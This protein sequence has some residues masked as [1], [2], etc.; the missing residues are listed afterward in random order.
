MRSASSAPRSC[1][2]RGGSTAASSIFTRAIDFGFSKTPRG[3]GARSGTSAEML[4]R[5]GPGHPHVPAA[6]RSSRAS[7]GTAADGHGHH[8]M[9]GYLTPLAFRA[10]ADP[11]EFPDQ[12][13][14][15][16]CGRGRRGSSTRRAIARCARHAG[17]RRPACSIRCSAGPMPKSPSRA[18]ASTSRRRW[19]RSRSRRSADLDV[20]EPIDQRGDGPGTPERSMFDGLDVTRARTRQRSRDCRTARSR[21]ELAAID[22]AAKKALEE[23]RAARA[24]AHRAAAGRR[25][26]RPRARPRQALP[27]GGRA[28]RRTRRRGL[29]ARGQG[30][31]LHDG[32]GPGRRRR[33]SIRWPTRKRRFRAARFGVTVRLFLTQPSAGH[34]GLHGASRR[35]RAGQSAGAGP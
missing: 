10:A 12:L 35:R 29:P 33:S 32:P 34:A 16:A 14:R 13:Q 30:A 25:A 4:G 23:L 9:A 1:C 31:R 18:A 7:S 21:A 24:I 15:R 26:C 22:G 11:N 3:S 5:H 28:G 19:A 6:R 20:F 17:R 27:P 8:Q 2:R